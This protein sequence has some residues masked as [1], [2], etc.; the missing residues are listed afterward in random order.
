VGVAAC[1]TSGDAS[2]THRRMKCGRC[3]SESMAT[4]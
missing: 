1:A 2:G 3:L 4:L